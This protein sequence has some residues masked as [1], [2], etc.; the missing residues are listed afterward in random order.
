MIQDAVSH[1]ERRRLCSW[2]CGDMSHQPP[3]LVSEGHLSAK[4][5][6][7]WGS[8]C[9]CLGALAMSAAARMTSCL[10]RFEIMSSIDHP[11]GTWAINFPGLDL[12]FL[13]CKWEKELRWSIK[14]LLAHLVL[15]LFKHISLMELNCTP[16]ELP[17]T[18]LHGHFHSPVWWEQVWLSFTVLLPSNFLL[19][20]TMDNLDHS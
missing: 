12:C 7:A 3:A 5:R 10:P 11:L 16:S 19:R 4:C 13:I 1:G 14:C 9:C 6:P 8:S 17:S 15:S 18:R 2:A 20:S